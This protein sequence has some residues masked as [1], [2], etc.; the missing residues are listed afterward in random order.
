MAQRG[1]NRA[2]KAVELGSVLVACAGRVTLTNI[3]GDLRV[4]SGLQ[5]AGEGVEACVAA[6]F[7]VMRVPACH[8]DAAVQLAQEG[9]LGGV[10]DDAYMSAPHDQ[11][12]RLRMLHANERRRTL[13]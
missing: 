13:I 12:A 2:A 10:H 3:V 6:A 5:L 1:W 9:V 8:F 7:P 11:V 4:G